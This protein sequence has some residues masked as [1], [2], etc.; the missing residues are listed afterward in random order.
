MTTQERKCEMNECHAW[1]AVMITVCIFILS[2][3]VYQI[4]RD[5]RLDA[6]NICIGENSDHATRI[7]CAEIVWIDAPAT[8]QP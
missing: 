1:I 2:I 8:P 7:K 4:G 6:M 3:A 5:S